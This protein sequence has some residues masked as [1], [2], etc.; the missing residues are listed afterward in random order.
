MRSWI[1]KLGKLIKV[2]GSPYSSVYNSIKV[3]NKVIMPNIRWSIGKKPSGS[4]D[5][6][7]YSKNENDLNFIEFPVSEEEYRFIKKSISYVMEHYLDIEE[8]RITTWINE[9][10][11]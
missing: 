8:E 2:K 9:R 5:I 6:S 3:D 4:I 10:L 1:E 7:E 11:D